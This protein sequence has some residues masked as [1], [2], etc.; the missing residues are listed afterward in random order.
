MAV[1][2]LL[3]IHH[4]RGIFDEPSLFLL[5]PDG[6]GASVPFCGVPPDLAGAGDE[7]A[8]R[9]CLRNGS[10]VVGAGGAGRRHGAPGLQG[11][12][13]P[14]RAGL[15]LERLLSW[16][17][18]RLGLGQESFSRHG[19]RNRLG[20]FFRR[21]RLCRRPD[22]G[23]WVFG[24]EGEASVAHIRKGVFGGFCGGFQNFGCI[25]PQC[26][27]FQNFGCAPFGSSCGGF[28][29]F[30]CFGQLGARIEQMALLTGRIG[31]AWGP[32]LAYA[33]GGLAYAHERY[34][35]NTPGVLDTIT[36]DDRWGWTLG[37]GIEYG[38][39]AKWSAKLEYNFIDFGTK[40]LNF[41]SP[42]GLAFAFD[43]SQRVHLAK[44]GI[45]Y[46]FA[47][48]VVVARY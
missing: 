21:R 14:G 48:E 15:Q 11:G 16:W 28:Q 34:V 46:R 29:N 39:A 33:K 25:P 20:G 42:T 19:V 27:G 7:A 35:F 45:N 2:A 3:R 24:I 32:W 8:V 47:P 31:H 44:F 1:R 17:A 36:D 9:N 38:F 22:R 23:A 30:G 43:H 41:V 12:T 4:I 5:L 37:A 18:R 6:T 26:G 13:G 40:R 10:G